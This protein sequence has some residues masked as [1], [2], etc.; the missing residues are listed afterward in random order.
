MFA[1]LNDKIDH[2]VKQNA[3]KEVQQEAIVL[4]LCDPNK[5]SEC[6][7]N[8][9]WGNLKRSAMEK[10]DYKSTTGAGANRNMVLDEVDYKVLDIIGRN[11][12]TIVGHG[13]L[14]ATGSNHVTATVT[15]ASTVARSSVIGVSYVVGNQPTTSAINHSYVSPTHHAAVS[16]NLFVTKKEPLLT[17]SEQ[18]LS[19]R[20][21]KS[22]LTYRRQIELNNK[23][24]SAKKGVQDAKRAKYESTNTII[25]GSARDNSPSKAKIAA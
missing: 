3:W 8:T 12:P 6:V 22:P 10:H 2:Q 20:T 24:Y 15:N 25:A 17:V 9:V 7:R 18:F 16:R 11:N 14:E 4:G 13:L 1:K 21:P 5:D 23:R 19:P